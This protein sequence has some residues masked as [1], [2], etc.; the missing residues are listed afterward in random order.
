[1]SASFYV[2]TTSDVPGGVLEYVECDG[3]RM[4]QRG[5]GQE[6]SSNNDGDIKAPVPRSL[7]FST[8]L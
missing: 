3:A 5:V 7:G 2:Q 4:F 1:M 6:V 8:R